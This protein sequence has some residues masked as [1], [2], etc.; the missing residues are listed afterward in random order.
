MK[1]L[2]IF[3]IIPVTMLTAC[4]SARDAAEGENMHVRNATYQ[5]WFG[6]APV[7]FGGRERGTDLELTL[8]GWAEGYTPDYVVFQQKK[9]FS[10]E[11]IEE[12]NNRV[13]IKARIIHE[14]R[15]LNEISE[16]VDVPA[17]LVFT[18][19]DGD[20]G[21]IEIDEWEKLPDVYL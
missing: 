16:T 10:A 17:R 5:N 13:V 15:L 3:I 21:F 6:E 18:H 20:T 8:E 4:V 7:E 12:E 14:S 19:S 2:F 9:S 1:T 11:I